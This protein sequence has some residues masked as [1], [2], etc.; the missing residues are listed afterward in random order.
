MPVYT[1]SKDTLKDFFEREINSHKCYFNPMI[2]SEWIYDHKS[3][4]IIEKQ[5]PRLMSLLK[6]VTKI[7]PEAS[8]SDILTELISVTNKMF[9]EHYSKKIVY[10]KTNEWI[11]KHFFK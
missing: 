10:E 6:K 4:S 5:Y 8:Q 1:N 2:L 7:V 11:N 3:D 9:D